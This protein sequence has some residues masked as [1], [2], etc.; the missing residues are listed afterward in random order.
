V[1]SA[2]VLRRYFEVEMTRDIDAIL[3]LYSPDA[4]FATPDA[5]RRGR[6][7]IRPFYEDAAHRFPHLDVKVTVAFSDGQLA[8]AE[9][10]AVMS[11]PEAGTL[12]LAGANV[13]RIVDGL[14]VDV[15]SYYDTSSY[16]KTA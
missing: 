8:V 5:V 9:W 6:A 12:S 4:V 3:D 15:R 10:D 11:G 2:D 1:N 14:I 7:E 13:A 16:A